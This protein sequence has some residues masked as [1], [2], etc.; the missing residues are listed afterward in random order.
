M[1]QPLIKFENVSK[2]FGTN[3]VLK[4]VSLSIYQGEV[5]AIIGK[6]GVGKSVLLKHIIGLMQPDAGEIFFNGRPLSR[7]K[8]PEIDK[9]REKFSY[10]FQD[11]ALFDSMTVR[12]NIAFPLRGGTSLP[13]SEVKSRVEE[14]MKMFELQGVHDKY[15]SQISGGMKRRLAL[16]RAL[17]TEP[18]VVLLD[19]PTTGLDPIRKNAVYSMI[20]DLQ[21]KIGF[22]AVMISHEIPDIFYFSQRIAMLNDGIICFEGTPEEIRRFSDPV[23]RQFINGLEKPRDMLTGMA[24]R[25]QV[26]RKFQEELARLQ[27]HRIDFCV[28]MLTVENIDEINEKMGH[29]T[30]LTI[31]KNFAIQI[32]QRLDITDSCS[33]Y[34]LDKI[35]IVLHNADIN[36]ARKFVNRLARELIVEDLLNNKASA[37]LTIRISAGYAQAEEDSLLKEVLSKAESKDSLYNEFELK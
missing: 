28:V 34:S 27:L 6:S 31:I 24:T 10:V 15:P 29:M 26:E 17:V 35:L 22:S 18:E 2:S 20:V 12:E 19:E 16:A 3:Q 5:T 30:G 1:I 25:T 9:L 21:K 7:M 11:T 23:V 8:N 32:Q 36:E 14:K 33:R 4:E 13:K 37:K